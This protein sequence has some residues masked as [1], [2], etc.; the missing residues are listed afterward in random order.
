MD[1]AGSLTREIEILRGDLVGIIVRSGLEVRLINAGAA[2]GAS[3]PVQSLISLFAG[4]GGEKNDF[5]LPDYPSPE[6]KGVA[7]DRAA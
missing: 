4:R 5:V 1:K 7:E 2:I 3:G 6:S